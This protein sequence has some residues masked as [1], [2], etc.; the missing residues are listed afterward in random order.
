MTAKDILEKHCKDYAYELNAEPNTTNTCEL[1]ITYHAVEAANDLIE[2]R[3]TICVN[4]VPVFRWNAVSNKPNH[5]QVCETLLYNMISYGLKCAHVNLFNVL[6]KIGE[7][8][9]NR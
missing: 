4:T 5:E 1:K 8:D 3:A 7:N 6:N 9:T 2:T